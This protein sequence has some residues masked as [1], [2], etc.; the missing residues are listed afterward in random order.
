MLYKEHTE[1]N[2]DMWEKLSALFTPGFNMED[3]GEILLLQSSFPE[4]S[5][6]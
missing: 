3:L 2:K 1:K 6:E 4:E 5:P